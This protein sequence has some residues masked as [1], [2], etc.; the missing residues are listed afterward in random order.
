MSLSAQHQAHATALLTD[1]HAGAG[2]FLPRREDIE[3]WLRD[4]LRRAA[5]KGYHVD[6][7]DAE[8][9]QALDRYVRAN[10]TPAVAG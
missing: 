2:L 5:A 10:L 8:N 1:L 4:F 6:E 3:L 7:G 9:L